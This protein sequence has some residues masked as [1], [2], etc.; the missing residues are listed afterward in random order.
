MLVRTENQQI[1]LI[2]SYN[3]RSCKKERYVENEL[4]RKN[5][6]ENRRSLTV[7]LRSTAIMNGV[8]GTV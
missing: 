6:Y 3:L 2:L 7:G 5:L 8:Q 4:Q 1:F